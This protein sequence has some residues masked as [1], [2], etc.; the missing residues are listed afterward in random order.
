MAQAFSSPGRIVPGMSNNIQPEQKM[1]KL[2]V[3]AAFDQDDEGGFVTALEP[4]Q[5]QAE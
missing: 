5:Q 1:P 4:A 3:G 2:I